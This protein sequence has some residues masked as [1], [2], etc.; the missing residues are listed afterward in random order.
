MAKVSLSQA[1]KLSFPYIPANRKVSKEVLDMVVG[2][3]PDDFD[4]EKE[5]DKMWKERAM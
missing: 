2:T 4:V 3:L 5:M 1:D